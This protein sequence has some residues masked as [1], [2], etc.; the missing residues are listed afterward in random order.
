MPRSDNGQ[1]DAQGGQPCVPD[2][3]RHVA[4]IQVH[5]PCF[6]HYVSRGEHLEMARKNSKLEFLMGSAFFE[7]EALRE[8]DQL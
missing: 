7:N 8:R 2:F 3:V 4:Q 5:W 1:K 6:L